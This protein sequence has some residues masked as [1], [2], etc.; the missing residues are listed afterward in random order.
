MAMNLCS[1][2]GSWCAWECGITSQI[3]LL[4]SGA[5]CAK[6]SLASTPTV[7]KLLSLII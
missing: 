5:S 7:W 3:L 2:L 4:A 1:A 6:H